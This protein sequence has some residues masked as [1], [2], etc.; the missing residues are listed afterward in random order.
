MSVWAFDAG[1]KT[2][3]AGRIYSMAKVCQSRMKQLGSMMKDYS[4]LHNGQYPASDR[5]CD[6]I[7]TFWKSKNQGMVERIVADM[8]R[9]G[10]AERID[11]AISNNA[12]FFCP[13]YSGR[14]GKQSS[15]AIN[16]NCRPDSPLDTVL[17]FETEAGWNKF[18]GPESVSFN[19]KIPSI[20]PFR[21]EKGCNVLFDDGH[22]ELIDS[23]KIGKLK[24]KDEKAR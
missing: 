22:A 16:P 4:Q 7:Y 5:W 10:D 21:W 14:H 19:H 8:E 18:G 3:N 15:Y 6:I 9:D 11:F 1:G 20:L 23:E 24:W 12:G 17:L 13:G 2:L